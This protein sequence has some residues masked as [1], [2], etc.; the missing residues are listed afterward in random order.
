MRESVVAEKSVRVVSCMN[1]SSMIVVRC[2]EGVK[3]PQDGGGTASGI[4]QIVM[5]WSCA[6]EGQRF[7]IYIYW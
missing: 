2:A 7:C 3:W 5:V 4:S 6:M 1:D